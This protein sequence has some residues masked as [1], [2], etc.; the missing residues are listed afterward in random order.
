MNRSARTVERIVDEIERALAGELCLVG[1]RDL[2]R[3]GRASLAPRTIARI[4]QEIGLAHVEVEIDRIERDERREQCGRAGSGAAASDQ[5]ADGDEMRADA[6]GEGRRDA[7]M[8]EI[9]LAVADLRL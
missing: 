3:V 6:A 1:E 7:A 8:F 9:E 4:G 5:V 2:N